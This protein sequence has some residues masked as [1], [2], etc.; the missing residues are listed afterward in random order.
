MQGE[1]D[2]RGLA[3][4]MA[5]MR[6]VSILIILMHFYWFCYYFFLENGWT[7]ELIN[8][9]LSNFQKTA[10]LF[11]NILYTKIFSLV[12][13]SLSCLG[14]KGVKNEKITWPKIKIV[15]TIGLALF[16]LNFPLLKT[17]SEIAVFF[18]IM[19]TTLG[20]I[21]LMVGGIWMSRL[22]KNNLVDDIFNNEN[23]SFWQETKLMEN[24]YSVN[25]PT[26]FYY[27]GKWNKGWIN[28]VNPFRATIV[29]GTPGSGKSYA[30]VNNYIKQQI[31]KGF[32]MYIYDFKFDDLSTIAYN[33]LLKHQDNYKVAP[34]FYVINF[35]DPQKSH[36]CN[37]LNPDFMTDIS[38]A[39]EAAYTIML[40]L[41]RSWIQKQG[42]FFV[43]SP[44]ILLAAIIWY[45]KIYDNGKYCTFPHAI[46]L[47]NKKYS[48]VFTILTSYP[49]L[50]N[51]LS[52]FMDAWQGGAQD[53]LQGQI[54]SAKIPLSRMI[55]PQLYWVM[56]GDDFSLDINN[57]KEPKILC[58]G[59]NPDRQNIYSAA[60]GLYNSRIVKLINKKGQLKS[61]IIIDELPTIYFRGL[62]N[63]I[64][65]A[66]SNKVAVCLGFQDF[67]QLT[68]DYGDK[69]SKVIQNTVGNIFSGQVVGET[70]KSLSER[71]G[72]VLQ[73]RQSMTINR[74]DKSTSI[75]T[76]LDSLIPASKISTLTQGIFVG[77][78]SDN[79]DERIEQKIF[80]AEIVVDNEKVVAETKKYQKIPQIRSFLDSEG[81]DQMQMHIENNYRQIKADI[82]NIIKS[83]MQRIKNDPD[84]QHLVQEG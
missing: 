53:Q 58:V 36:R 6:A 66:R 65:T 46:E 69:E 10:G 5:F 67:S 13:L 68:R 75:S 11:S 44:I 27:K 14:T 26:K 73:N 64:A 71:F 25:L 52:P 23:E 21:L 15:L 4:I 48:E 74:S 12:L 31:E 63:L 30:I 8:K 7:L 34:K 78:V 62:D 54:A 60:L 17:S 51:Y 76:Q 24:E 2:L 37:P 16:F 83:E 32:S 18:Y 80:H 19:T 3:K 9:I 20:Y 59:N 33:H 82:V 61:S 49:D 55:S 70:A 42:D 35:D 28:I 77:A 81:K 45:L 41:N 22:L 72:K 1:D 40:N 29:L 47:L 39:Y 57:P 56:T 84:L 38:D 50:E 79:Y 43:E